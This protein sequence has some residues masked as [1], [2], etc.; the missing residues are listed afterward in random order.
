[1]QRIS[2]YDNQAIQ[3]LADTATTIN[4]KLA[5][6]QKKPL[7]CNEKPQESDYGLM[8]DITLKNIH[9]TYNFNFWGSIFQKE[10]VNLAIEAQRRGTYSK[11]WD[12]VEEF[13]KDRLGAF[14]TI[15]YTR[16]NTL[17]ETVH[18]LVTPN[19][20]DVL[21]CLSPM[22]EDSFEDFCGT[23]GYNTDSIMAE[24]T[25]RA[26]VEQD[27]NIRKLWDMA[28]LEKLSEIN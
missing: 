27:R 13:V 15:H 17:I 12:K 26:C 5:P 18:T 2:E 9:H 23:F 7:W 20:Y 3:F 6:E 21:S 1:M 16:G 10:M 8:Y 25:Y 14:T 11:E 19:S 22:Y 4:I 24:K 28:E